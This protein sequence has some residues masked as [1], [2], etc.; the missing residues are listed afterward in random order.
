MNAPL[1]TNITLLNKFKHFYK[2][3]LT[4]STIKL[5]DIY[6]DDIV[7]TDPVHE[8]H[9]L[10]NLM[11]YLDSSTENLEQCRFEY[12][13]E[14]VGDG[15]AF[16]KWNMHFKHP[17]VSP[18]VQTLR[19]VTHLHFDEKITYHEDVYDMGAMVYEHIPIVGFATR[20]IKRRMAKY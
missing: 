19:G 16:I 11:S 14:I 15:V 7:F 9:G 10:A 17:G 20:A 13:D 8:V 1:P 6:T 3:M 5:D 4:P 12:L 18:H 2:D